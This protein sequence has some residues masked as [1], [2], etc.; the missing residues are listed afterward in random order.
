MTDLE[1]L[2]DFDS[3]EPTDPHLALIRNHVQQAKL[4]ALAEAVAE[5]RYPGFDALCKKLFAREQELIAHQLIER[6]LKS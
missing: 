2:V 3:P 6:T 1:R 5:E 4:A